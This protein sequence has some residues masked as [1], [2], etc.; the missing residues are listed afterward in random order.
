LVVSQSDMPGWHAR[1]DGAPAPIYRAYGVIQALVVPPGEHAIELEYAPDGL[2]TG[3]WTSLG[4][5]VVVLALGVAGC[6]KR[7]VSAS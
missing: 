3:A 2:V 7:R 5:L 6:T 4:A 1:I